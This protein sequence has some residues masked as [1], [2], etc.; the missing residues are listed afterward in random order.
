MSKCF[1]S[2]RGHFPANYSG[3]LHT[4]SLLLLWWLNCYMLIKFV[5]TKNLV[6]Y[7]ENT[8]HQECLS[9]ISFEKCFIAENGVHYDTLFRHVKLV[10][11]LFIFFVKRLFYRYT[12]D[13]YQKR[14]LFAKSVMF[15]DLLENILRGLNFILS[16]K[17]WW[18]LA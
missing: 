9:R 3:L 1:I 5:T 12:P 8:T 13:I 15:H 11:F 4:G 7:S 17:L 14:I 6:C 10:Y 16:V 18:L 2:T